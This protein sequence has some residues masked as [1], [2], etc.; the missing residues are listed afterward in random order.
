MCSLG[1]VR[2]FDLIQQSTLVEGTHLG[3]AI[4]NSPG[5]VKVWLTS[6]FETQLASMDKWVAWFFA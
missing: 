6:D 1:I 4:L 5:R 2:S 3:A